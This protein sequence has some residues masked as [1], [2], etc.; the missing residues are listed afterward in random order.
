MLLHALRLL[1][2]CCVLQ[3]LLD[4]LLFTHSLSRVM[5]YKGQ[6]GLYAYYVFVAWLLR[7][8]APP[9]ASMTAQESALVGSF[10]CEELRQCTT[11]CSSGMCRNRT[12]LIR[13]DLCSST[14]LRTPQLRLVACKCYGWM[15]RTCSCVY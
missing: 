11:A 15:P 4:V 8:I 9:L 13:Q 5:G 1:C 12:C 6:L 7:A 14:W 10:R 3:P 2:C